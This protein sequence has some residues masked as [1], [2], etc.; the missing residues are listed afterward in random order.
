MNATDTTGVNV[1]RR[2]VL[3]IILTSTLVLAFMLLHL[4]TLKERCVGLDADIVGIEEE[5]RFFY[6]SRDD[7]PIEADLA[8][9][10]AMYD[11]LQQEWEHL[12]AGVATFQSRSSLAETLPADEEGRIDFKVALFEARA[13]LQEQAAA[14]GVTVPLDLGIDETIGADEHAETRLWQ[15][16]AI[17]EL[18][19]QSVA[20]GIPSIDS[21]ES[22]PTIIHPLTEEENAVAEEFPVRLTMH[23]PFATFLEFIDALVDDGKFF[24]LRRFWLEKEGH[25]NSSNLKITT[26]CGS[27]LFR[28]RSDEDAVILS[29]ESSPESGGLDRGTDGKEGE[30]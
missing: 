3:F 5:M 19:E 26:V 13:R 6:K 12:R 14:R 29:G 24:A 7:R 2:W 20:L 25:R 27:V 15:L 18:L 23:G 16:S 21:I 4:L 28:L 11:H 10:A 9:T 30:R 8:R 17:I 22:L 1:Q